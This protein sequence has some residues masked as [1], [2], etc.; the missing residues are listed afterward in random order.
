MTQSAYR[1]LTL[2]PEGGD[3]SITQTEMA[4]AAQ[5]A[6][7]IQNSPNR[8]TRREQE[9]LALIAEGWTT[10][11]IAARLEISF[12]TAVCHRSHLMAKMGSRNSVT[13][14]LCAIRQGFISP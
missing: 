8:L 5:A 6:M 14:V 11:Q 9:V 1:S 10:K 3:N 12:K 4:V 2:E 13:L 7:A